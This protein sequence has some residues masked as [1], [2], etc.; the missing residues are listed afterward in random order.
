M[1][2]N[3]NENTSLRSVNS[4]ETDKNPPVEEREN[5]HLTECDKSACVCASTA[6]KVEDEDEDEDEDEEE[7]DEEDDELGY[8]FTE[9]S[10]LY[11]I[12]VDSVPFCYVKDEESAIQRM[13]DITIQFCGERVLSGWRTSFVKVRKNELHLLGS[14]KFFL[15]AYDQVLRRVSYS[16][17]RECV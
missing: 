6:E 14:Y 16:R 7:D 8:T 4:D 5:E 10:D 11:V 15:I 1:S 13:W 17:I 3:V 12:S 9:N 2:D